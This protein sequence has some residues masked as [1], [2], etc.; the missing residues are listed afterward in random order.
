MQALKWDLVVEVD[1]RIIVLLFLLLHWLASSLLVSVVL[2]CLLALRLL[3][4]LWCLL[5]LLSLLAA[6]LLRWQLNVINQ[7]AWA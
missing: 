7:D 1:W 5:V 4:D 6:L 2:R 3:L